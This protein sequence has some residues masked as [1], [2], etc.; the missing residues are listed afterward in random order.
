MAHAQVW[1]GLFISYGAV[2]IVLYLLMKAALVK[3]SNQSNDGILSTSVS[4]VSSVLTAQGE[5]RYGPLVS[6][7]KLASHCCVH[8]WEST[9]GQVTTAHRGRSLVSGGHHL[10]QFIQRPFG[11]VPHRA[12]IRASVEHLRGRRG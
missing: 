1:L 6:I 7:S 2:I 3:N 4:Y 5:S 12:E 11:F 9:F 8:R 10:E